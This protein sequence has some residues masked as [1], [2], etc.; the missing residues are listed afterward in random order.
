MVSDIPA[1]LFLVIGGYIIEGIQSRSRAAA[2]KK[3]ISYRIQEII[4]VFPG[5]CPKNEQAT[6]QE[7]EKARGRKGES[8]SGVKE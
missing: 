5:R 7:R 3:T 8:N 2:P 1:L 4:S 6:N